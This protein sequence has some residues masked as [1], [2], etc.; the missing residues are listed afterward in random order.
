M[1]IIGV[2]R[3]QPAAMQSPYVTYAAAVLL[4]V[5]TDSVDTTRQD[6]NFLAVHGSVLS[7][8]AGEDYKVSL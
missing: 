3:Q 6:E 5:T 7:M 8:H 4:S 2:H 1:I